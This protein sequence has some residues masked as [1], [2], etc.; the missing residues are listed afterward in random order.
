MVATRTTERYLRFLRLKE[1]VF[2]ALSRAPLDAKERA[3]LD[4]VV[5]HWKL[6][7][8]LSVREAMVS[9]ARLGSPS[10]VQRRL[11]RLKELGYLTHTSG[12]S[13]KKIKWLAP[14]QLTLT[15]FNELG[16]AMLGAMK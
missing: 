4:I 3:L 7:E 5:M 16:V 14:T 8:P 9:L 1:A 12:P 6:D 11:S 2:L 15:Y 13:N 10:T